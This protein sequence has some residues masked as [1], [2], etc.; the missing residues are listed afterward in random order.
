MKNF[1]KWGAIIVGCLAVVII[2]A[3]LII[4][5]FVDLQKYKPV[6]ENKVVEATGRPF[7]VGDDL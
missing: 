2:A 1:L 7:S 6:I 4:P 5:I 3:L